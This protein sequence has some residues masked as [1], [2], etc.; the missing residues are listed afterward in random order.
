MATT[1]TTADVGR[2]A[3]L[4]NIPVT[5]EEK[6][7]LAGGFTKTMAAIEG[8]TKVDVSEAKDVHV[9][10]LT[11]VFREDEIDES[12]MFTQKQALANAANTDSGYFVVGRV[13]D[14]E[15]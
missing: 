10:G 9:T 8:L 11:N 1:F 2:I 15:E 4:A 14:E 13:I 6:T 3:T 7:S 5:E 12:R